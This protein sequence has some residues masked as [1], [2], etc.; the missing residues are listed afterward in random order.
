MQILQQHM[1]RMIANKKR[2]AKKSQL[3]V[4][5]VQAQL[6]LQTLS[7]CEGTFGPCLGQLPHSHFTVPPGH[8][9]EQ[10]ESRLPDS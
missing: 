2:K 9:A 5:Q 3:A 10:T 7:S 4:L 8:H 1:A 6:Q